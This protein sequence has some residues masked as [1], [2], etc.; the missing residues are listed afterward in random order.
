M[1]PDY[2]NRNYARIE[3]KTLEQLEAEL[4]E[5]FNRY[6]EYS[7]P[8]YGQAKFDHMVRMFADDD[9]YNMHWVARQYLSLKEQR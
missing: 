4:R 1:T 2:G 9:F 6:P 3:G 7:D 5:V 8:D